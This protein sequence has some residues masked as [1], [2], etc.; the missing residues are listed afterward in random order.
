MRVQG[1]VRKTDDSCVSC[2]RARTGSKAEGAPQSA[3]NRACLNTPSSIMISATQDLS[4]SS[5]QE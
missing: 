2:E 5:I 4:S 3:I 1:C